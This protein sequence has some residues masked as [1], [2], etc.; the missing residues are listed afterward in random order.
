MIDTVH[1][2]KSRL[3]L[4]ELE[5]NYWICVSAS[6]PKTVLQSNTKDDQT[7]IIEYFDEDL[8]DHLV[9]LIIKQIYETFY[10]FKG[11]ITNLCNK[12][13]SL[14]LIRKQCS[15]FFDWFLQTIKLCSI[16]LV[17]LF[18]AIT[19]LPLDNITYIETQSFL[20]HITLCDDFCKFI[21]FLY[22]DQLIFSSLDLLNTKIIYRYLITQ[23]I[24]EAVA[25]ELGESFKSKSSRT[26]FMKTAIPIYLQK[27]EDFQATDSASERDDKSQ[28]SKSSSTRIDNAQYLMNIYRSHNGSTIVLIT[29]NETQELLKKYLDKYHI[30][31]TTTLPD[32]TAKLAEQSMKIV[33]KD[34]Y[35]H[36][37]DQQ[38]HDKLKYTYF[39]SSNAAYKSNLSSSNGLLDHQKLLDCEF[40][41]L[42]IDIE[43]DLRTTLDSSNGRNIVELLA[44]TTNETWLVIN[45]SDGRTL[46]SFLNHKNANLLEASETVNNYMSKKLKNILFIE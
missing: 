27:N 23:V 45:E 44:K 15:G 7:E 25:E 35:V 3:V 37:S 2:T 24:S 18:G 28:S 9:K 11:S 19:Y 8:N 6:I 40:V 38:I 39:S 34:N 4:K 41:K 31:L 29:E 1:G 22:N 36:N 46:Y 43:S 10:L 13:R 33:N 17:E 21:L 14:D 20:N 42:I 26:R 30:N 5:P 32:L 16:N 12:C